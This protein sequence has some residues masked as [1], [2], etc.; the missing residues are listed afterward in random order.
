MNNLPHT[1]ASIR[2]ELRN[3]RYTGDIERQMQTLLNEYDKL[4]DQYK[5]LA[6]ER[7]KEYEI[8]YGQD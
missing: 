5:V 3:K 1:I 2:D 7:L 6:Q 4:N 8:N